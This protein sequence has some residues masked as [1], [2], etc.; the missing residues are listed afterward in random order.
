MKLTHINQSGRA[1]MV[2]V[3]EKAETNRMAIATGIIRMKKST[4]NLIKNSD[5]KKGDVLAVAQIAGITGAKKTSD[6]I[7][8]C[9]NIFISGADID[10]EFKNDYIRVFAKVKT[11]SK[12]GIEMEALTAVSMS[13]LTIYDMCKAVDKEMK[14]DK[15]QLLEKTG[16]KSNDLKFEIDEVWDDRKSCSNK[17]IWKK[18]HN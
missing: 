11:Q 4:I 9:H 15:I 3:G 6:L 17:Y 18:G 12:T 16:G 2:D 8:M 10:F 1:K 5:I 13:L 14:I 7:P